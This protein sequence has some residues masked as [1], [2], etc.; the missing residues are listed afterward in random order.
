[1]ANIIITEHAKFESQRRG[2]DFALM[3]SIIEHPQQRVRS[4]KD[5]LVLQSRYFE[6]NINKEMLL[7]VIVEVAGDKLTVIS[8]YKTTKIDKYWIGEERYESDL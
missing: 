7:R 6:K 5:R 2:I 8:V 1:M 3:L 4:K